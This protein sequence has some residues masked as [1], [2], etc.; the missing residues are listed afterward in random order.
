MGGPQSKADRDRIRQKAA[1]RAPRLPKMARINA[2]LTGAGLTL[3][4]LRERQA[5]SA[6]PHIVAVRDQV[7]RMCRDQGLSLPDI[8]D[9]M[10]RDHKT[11]LHSLNKRKASPSEGGEA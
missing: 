1:Q 10:H 2:L 3:A 4:D 7:I 9:F 8:G 11:V 5:P 6:A